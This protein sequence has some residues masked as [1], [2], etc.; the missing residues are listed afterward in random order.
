[1]WY[2]GFV[3]AYVYCWTNLANG[4][5]YIGKGTGDRALRHV[6]RA[7][8]GSKLH[9]H[10]YNAIRHHGEGAFVLTYLAFGLDDSVALDLETAAIAAYDSIASGYN[11][12]VGGAGSAGAV[13]SAESKARLSAAKRGRRP[14][15]EHA[16]KAAA[17]RRGL[18]R[19]PEAVRKTAEANR[20]KKHPPR[21]EEWV[22]K[23][24]EAHTGKRHTEE[25]K[26]RMRKAAHLREARRRAA[27]A[28]E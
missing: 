6:G 17:A 16:A 9:P 12:T 13:W 20:G 21:S 19:D 25:T 14:S 2:S 15:A 11:L 7:L 26:E 8:N 22:R 24:T 27:K 28:A 1:M 18:R 10:F 23:Q 4:R 3:E 5:C